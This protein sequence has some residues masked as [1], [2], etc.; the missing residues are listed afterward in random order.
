MGIDRVVQEQNEK[1]KYEKQVDDSV[2]TSSNVNNHEAKKSFTDES[3]TKSQNEDSIKGKNE[4][5][6]ATRNPDHQKKIDKV[7]SIFNI[8]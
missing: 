8:K 3:R 4:N 1:N 2:N 7:K 6:I 5:T